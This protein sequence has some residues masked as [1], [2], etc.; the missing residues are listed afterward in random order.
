MWWYNRLR[1]PGVD[2]SSFH[3][4][5]FQALQE[6]YRALNWRVWALDL[7]NDL[8]IPTFVALG[9]SS[10]TG[11]YCIGFGTHLDPRIALQLSLAL[12]Q[13]SRPAGRHRRGR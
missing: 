11:A 3:D 6:H 5:Y 1:R 7:T 13:L 10:K 8:E 2:L 12:E 9:L 4:P